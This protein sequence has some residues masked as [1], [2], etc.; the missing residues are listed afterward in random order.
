MVKEYTTCIRLSSQVAGKE[1][2]GA[3][4]TPIS[5][6]AS[7]SARRCASLAPVIVTLMASLAIVSTS[8]LRRIILAIISAEWASTISG[9]V[10]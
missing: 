10:P 2:V 8:F 4:T 5:A 1:R 7:S 9:M 3:T 6:P